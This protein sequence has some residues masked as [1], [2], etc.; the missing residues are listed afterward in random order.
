MDEFLEELVK[1]C[2]KHNA[3]ILALDSDEFHICVGEDNNHYFHEINK[4]GLS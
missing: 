4:A 2:K 3:R 1:L